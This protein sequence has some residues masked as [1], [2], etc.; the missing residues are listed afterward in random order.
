M[1]VA[2]YLL[3]CF[4]MEVLR[5]DTRFNN[6]LNIIDSILCAIVALVH[7]NTRSCVY[8][9]CN[10]HNRLSLVVRSNLKIKSKVF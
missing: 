1:E 10:Q 8:L 5:N 9:F 6:Y 7:P 4:P 3:L 2:C